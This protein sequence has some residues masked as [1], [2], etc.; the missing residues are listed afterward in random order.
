M[1]VATF[2]CTM[3]LALSVL[4]TT[5]WGWV[6]FDSVDHYISSYVILLIGFC[7]CISVGWLFERESTASRSPEHSKSLVSLALFYWFPVIVLNFYSTF[8]FP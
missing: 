5:N 2:V 4:F 8:G 3:G 6:L 7:Q 1:K